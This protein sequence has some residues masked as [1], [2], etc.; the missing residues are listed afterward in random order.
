MVNKN[1][2]LTFNGTSSFINTEKSPITCDMLQAN[3]K[4][5]VIYKS[6]MIIFIPDKTSQNYI[7][8][9]NFSK[10]DVIFNTVSALDRYKDIYLLAQELK[11][12]RLL[13]P[14]DSIVI[15]MGCKV[16]FRDN[17]G[18]IYANFNME[19]YS[20]V[21]IKTVHYETFF[22]LLP[23][24][25]VSNDKN[26]ISMGK[27]GKQEVITPKT[28]ETMK[29]VYDNKV[30]IEYQ[31][32]DSIVTI[33]REV[34]PKGKAVEGLGYRLKGYLKILKEVKNTLDKSIFLPIGDWS[35]FNVQPF[36]S[37]EA[38]NVI[39]PLVLTLIV[40]KDEAEKIKEGE[41]IYKSNLQY[42]R[43]KNKDLFLISA[44]SFEKVF[45]KL[46]Y[47]LNTE[48]SDIKSVADFLGELGLEF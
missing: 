11:K 26:T 10:N 47:N 13:Y 40:H 1:E 19:N 35:L 7:N 39:N 42:I 3:G 18:I 5:F 34:L 4:N 12:Y 16:K 29:N 32:G 20:N 25:V 21:K 8:Y 33:E 17:K 44:E 9:H 22:N 43:N 31:F 30:P 45:F 37:Q 36:V 41:F 48:K 24:Y 46:K 14:N 15:D 38:S 23:N 2:D 28:L 27:N 6:G